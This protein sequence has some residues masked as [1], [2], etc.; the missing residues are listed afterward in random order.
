MSFSRRRNLR[1]NVQRASAR[2]CVCTCVCVCVCVCVCRCVAPGHEEKA[3]M[4]GTG[5]GGKE[6]RNVGAKWRFGGNPHD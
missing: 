6:R 1:R 2:V 4:A 3:M 5:G